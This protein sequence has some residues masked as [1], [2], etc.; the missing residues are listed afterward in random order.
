LVVEMELLAAR[1]ARSVAGLAPREATA[2]TLAVAGGY[3]QVALG[4]ELGI[5]P[6]H[7]RVVL[8]RARRHL[9]IALERGGSERPSMLLGAAG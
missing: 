4:A 2:L 1:I 7:A 9:R 6:G 5:T 3:D 8:H